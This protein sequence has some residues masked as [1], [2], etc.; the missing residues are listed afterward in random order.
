VAE[1]IIVPKDEA[2]GEFPQTKLVG[3]LY[4]IVQPE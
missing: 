3:G 2:G 4:G 1:N